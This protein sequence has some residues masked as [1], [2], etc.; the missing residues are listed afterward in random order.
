MS[1]H[2]NFGP[3]FQSQTTQS[4]TTELSFAGRLPQWLE[5]SLFRTGPSLFDIEG[6]KLNHLFDGMAKFYKLSFSGARQKVFF[7]SRFAC[8]NA[9]NKASNQGVLTSN[10]FGT[11]PER[12]RLQTLIEAFNFKAT[13]NPNVNV[14][15]M[16][17]RFLACTETP[18]VTE[19]EPAKLETL[20]H[21]KLDD[22]L[23]GQVSTAHPHFDFATGKLFNFLIEY[24]PTS[25][26]K[27]FSWNQG[28]N[29]RQQIATIKTKNPAYLHSFALTKN[30][31]VL[32]L[33]PLVVNP[34]ELLFSGKPFIANFKWKAELGTSIFVI[35]TRDGSVTPFQSDSF[36]VFHH[37]NASQVENR[38][39]VDLLAYKDAS[40]VQDLYLDKLA[41]KNYSPAI[42]L[43]TRFSI[44][45][46]NKKIEKEVFSQKGMELPTINYKQCNAAQYKHFYGVGENKSGDFL[47]QIVKISSESGALEAS[48]HEQNCYPSE[49]IFVANPG[50]KDD[51]V[52]ISVVTD[53]I[54]TASFCLIL[55]ARDLSELVRIEIPHLI[56]FH[57][58]GQFREGVI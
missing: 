23:N 29:K 27:L 3:L 46:K 10:E 30:Y 55:D 16:N 37:I 32:V 34:L 1:D 26:Y 2:T 11:S 42:P 54:K 4:Q 33:G 25:V 21:L 53:I 56:P 31:V 44:D 52:L 28:E 57:F 9:Y 58:H 48:W 17:Q 36:F 6:K 41:D 20:G 15:F 7:T 38:I 35:D 39:V 12:S 22:N 51:G 14:F 47:N 24:G 19:F 5:G 40:I 13:D 45:M 50:D 18:F 43:A 8:S 49:A